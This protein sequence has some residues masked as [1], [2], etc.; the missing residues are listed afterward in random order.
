MCI[1]HAEKENSFRFHVAVTQQDHEMD[2]WNRI[3]YRLPPLFSACE[4]VT[5]G[6]SFQVLPTFLHFGLE[7]DEANITWSIVVTRPDGEIS[8]SITD[9]VG[10]K[11]EVNSSGIVLSLD[12]ISM[13]MTEENPY[14]DYQLEITAVDHILNEQ[15]TVKIPIAHIPFEYKPD[16]TDFKK[17]FFEYP[18]HPRPRD[19]LYH[20]THL[21][22]PT[23]GKNGRI[24][25][26]IWLFKTIY[27]NNPFLIK[28]T[29]EFYKSKASKS[30][31]KEILFLFH[32]LGSI[33]ALPVE[34]KLLSYVEN[35]DTIEFANPYDEITTGDQLDMLWAEYFA[36]GRIRPIQH[37]LTA[38]DLG[39]Y[40]G[41]LEKVKSGE[42]NKKD[43][44]VMEAA[45]ANAVFDAAMWSLQSNCLQSRLLFHY[46]I[47]LYETKELS[48]MQKSCLASI[49][50]T[51]TQKL[52][53]EKDILPPGKN[54]LEKKRAIR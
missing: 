18:I 3:P 16:E 11:G 27:E 26:G 19:A 40:A 2:W 32:L 46:C 6:E 9:L 13:V 37:F 51:V 15:D 25:H 12:R 23:I 29:V 1:A 33:D 54:E 35:L 47:G 45:R 17:W 14:G 8:Q 36:T 21:I 22:R 34:K 20:L 4:Q 44:V 53:K 49:L 24:N 43:P 31:K 10:L 48:D 42:L 38:L 30:Q 39:V 52:K 28:P 5:T 7:N 50:N 41:T